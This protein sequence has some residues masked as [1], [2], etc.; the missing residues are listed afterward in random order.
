[1]LL[2]FVLNAIAQDKAP[3][4][5]RTNDYAVKKENLHNAKVISDAIP[6][7][8]SAWIDKVVST[9]IIGT[10]N[11]K[12]LVATGTSAE[13]TNAQRSILNSIDLGTELIINMKYTC[14]NGVSGEAESNNMH[15]S[16]LVVPETEAQFPGGLEEMSNYLKKN[17]LNALSEEEFKKLSIVIKFT[18]NER[19]EIHGGKI[20]GST[21]PGTELLLLEAIY[22]MPKWKPAVNS[23]GA[24]VK[25]EFEFGKKG[26]S[27]EG[28]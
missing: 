8:P 20:S 13:L 17:A 3:M 5:S 9:E 7:Y 19:G 6:A 24:S 23:S 28:C 12:T 2:L 21:D 15:F 14:R 27:G 22:K 16:A 4:F 10:C 25:Q 18:V 1:M 11:G 26:N